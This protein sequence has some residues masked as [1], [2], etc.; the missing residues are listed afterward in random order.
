ME[1]III[2]A[3]ILI[4]ALVFLVIGNLNSFFKKKLKKTVP[5]VNLCTNCKTGRESYIL[6]PASGV[7]PNISAWENG[8]CPFFE[9]VDDSTNTD[10]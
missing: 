2:M 10:I 6:D 7:C 3:T 4:L 9:P 5:Q 1:I 8:K